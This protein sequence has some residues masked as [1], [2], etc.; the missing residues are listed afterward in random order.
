MKK[1]IFNR[2]SC[3]KII[4]QKLETNFKKEIKLQIFSENFAN[5]RSVIDL[6]KRA[7]EVI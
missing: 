1:F 7:P 2:N 6:Y 4:L 3:L 5:Y